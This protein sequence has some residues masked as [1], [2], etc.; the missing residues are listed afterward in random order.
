MSI[1]KD[2]TLWAWGPNIF[3]QLGDGTLAISQNTPI[4]IGTAGDWQ[5]ISVGNLYTVALKKDG[6]LW[7]N[8]NGE[9]GDSTNTIKVSPEH[10]KTISCTPTAIEE[11]HIDTNDISLYPNPADEVVFIKNESHLVVDQINVL[12][13][14]GK[15]VL[16]TINTSSVNIASLAAGIYVVQILA[17]SMPYQ[18]RLVKR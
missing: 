3:G 2:G 13:M 1:K 18:Y 14:M 15:V 11:Q 12:D 5:L 17:G 4:E 7:V 6:T 16:T 9:L 8:T 10:I